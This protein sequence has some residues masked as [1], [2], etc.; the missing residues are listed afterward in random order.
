M[1][2]YNIV[3]LANQLGKGTLAEIIASEGLFFYKSLLSK[4]SL[5]LIYQNVKRF[6]TQNR[7]SSSLELIEKFQKIIDHSRNLGQHE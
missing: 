7:L 4:T 3:M 1:L 2:Y 6:L 5:S